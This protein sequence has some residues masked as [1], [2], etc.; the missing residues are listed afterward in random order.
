MNIQERFVAE[1]NE[2]EWIKSDPGLSSE[3]ANRLSHQTLNRPIPA[4]P[5]CTSIHRRCGKSRCDFSLARRKLWPAVTLLAGGYL[6]PWCPARRRRRWP[7]LKSFLLERFAAH[8]DAAPQY[9]RPV[10]RRSTRRVGTYIRTCTPGTRGFLRTRVRPNAVAVP[11]LAVPRRSL[12]MQR[13]KR[14]D[15]THFVRRQMHTTCPSLFRSGIYRYWDSLQFP[16]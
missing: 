6:F 9:P 4:S 3:R 12:T 15:S 14:V 1:S 13:G 7:R 2:P 5:A 10:L 11:L 8:R 16:I